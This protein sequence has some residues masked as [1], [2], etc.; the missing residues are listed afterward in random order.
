LVGAYGDNERTPSCPIGDREH[1][2]D[3]PAG[4]MLVQAATTSSLLDMIV[5]S[6]HEYVFHDDLSNAV[7]GITF[8]QER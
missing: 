4:P 2:H 7:T 5:F 6:S 3:D 1:Q 8:L